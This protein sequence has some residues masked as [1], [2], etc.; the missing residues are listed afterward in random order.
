[1]EVLVNTISSAVS[2]LIELI[3]RPVRVFGGKFVEAVSFIKNKIFGE[4]SPDAPP[5]TSLQQRAA[6]TSSLTDT[7]KIL[8]DEDQNL[9][10]AATDDPGS[11]PKHPGDTNIG[12]IGSDGTCKSSLINA[13]RN[14]G[15][16][17]QH[18]GAAVTG[19]FT[20]QQTAT[21]RYQLDGS[22][23]LCEL[24]SRGI[25]NPD[26]LASRS[27]LD[28]YDALV[29]AHTALTISE[30]ILQLTKRAIAKGI[31]VYVVRPAFDQTVRNNYREGSAKEFREESI[32]ALCERTKAEI[33]RSFG[34]LIDAKH[35][36]LCSNFDR[37]LYEL[38]D[39]KRSL[40]QVEKRPVSEQQ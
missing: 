4:S 23:F 21:E 36:Y 15:D 20:K 30:E 3:P 34:S 39:L 29:I 26:K 12:V 37:E 18:L 14:V 8:R 7:L 13:L 24:P 17:D 40:L 2:T 35:V 5:S 33:V 31:P 9:D 19:L 25:K 22:K 11:P 1:M 28:H 6:S 32:E 10:A 38:K 16:E 27:G